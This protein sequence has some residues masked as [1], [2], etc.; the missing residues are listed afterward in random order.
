MPYSVEKKA[1]LMISR[2]QRKLKPG[3]GRI[4]SSAARRRVQVQIKRL[5]AEATTAAAK[6]PAAPRPKKKLVDYAALNELARM[7]AIGPLGKPRP[8][9]KS[10][11]KKPVVKESVVK[12][13]KR[14]PTL[15][16]EDNAHSARKG[17]KARMRTRESRRAHTPTS[18]VMMQRQA[19][20]EAAAAAKA[21]TKRSK[22]RRP[23]KPS[24]PTLPLNVKKLLQSLWP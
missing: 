24:I 15:S 12:P 16:R 2:L 5:R 14:S 6:K 17:I 19:A 10:A 3:A 11:A 7:E 4:I 18:D 9:S 22:E 1:K 21:A 13:A 8:V 20:A 23:D